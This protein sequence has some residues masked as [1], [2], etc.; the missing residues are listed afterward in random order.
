MAKMNTQGKIQILSELLLLLSG[1]WYRATSR[2]QIILVSP[3]FSTL[4]SL[5]QVSPFSTSQPW[6]VW[7][8]TSEKSGIMSS[9]SSVIFFHS[10]LI[11]LGPKS[12]LVY[13]IFQMLRQSS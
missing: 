9:S 7:H 4:A 10:L 8:K 2:H 3:C 11:S 12:S 6:T 13:M 5:I 1:D